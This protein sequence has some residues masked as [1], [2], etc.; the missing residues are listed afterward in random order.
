MIGRP[1]SALCQR[2]HRRA[3][4]LAPH[5]PSRAPAGRGGRCNHLHI[6]AAE[7]DRTY[8]A[9]A[10]ASQARLLSWSAARDSQSEA[11]HVNVLL[12]P[13]S[14]RGHSAIARTRAITRRRIDC[15]LVRKTFC[16]PE[17]GA[18]SD[19]GLWAEPD[20]SRVLCLG[21]RTVDSEYQATPN[22]TRRLNAA[23]YWMRTSTSSLL[24][25]EASPTICP[26]RSLE[27]AFEFAR[28]AVYRWTGLEAVASCIFKTCRRVAQESRRRAAPRSRP[29]LSG[30]PGPAAVAITRGSTPPSSLAA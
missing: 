27:N 12:S 26:D 11:S 22:D 3:L 9:T 24:S 18:S 7:L 15:V 28:S 10:W 6:R 13:R 25:L 17:L 1:C 5:A 30:R 23:A 20:I 29:A 2:P 21:V 16:I 14:D 8:R 4:S 19:A